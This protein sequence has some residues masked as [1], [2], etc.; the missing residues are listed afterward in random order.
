[1]AMISIELKSQNS[2]LDVAQSDISST[3]K[4]PSYV[5]SVQL[6]EGKQAQMR[7][8]IMIVMII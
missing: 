3:T 2:N 1:M 8:V 5:K 4:P 6:Y 7:W